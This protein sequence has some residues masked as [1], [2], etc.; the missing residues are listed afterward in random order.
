MSEETTK[1]PPPAKTLGVLAEFAG[2]DELVEAA[3]KTTDAGYRKVEAFSPFPIHGIDD[4]LRA[5]KTLLPWLVFGAGLSGCVIAIAM[6]YY[7]NATEAWWPFSGYQYNISAKP[8][9][10]LPANIPVTFE[11]IILLSAF[12]SFFGM[13]ALNGLPM[14][15]NPLFKSERFQTATSHGFFLWIDAQDGK[16]DKDGAAEFL[17][18]IGATGS[19][20]IEQETAGREIPGFLLA[21][22]AVATAI[23]LVPPLWVAAAAGK[24]SQPRLSIW[25]C[26]DY[27]PKYKAQS[28]TSRELFADGRSMRSKVEGTVPRG[29]LDTD[30]RYYEGIQSETPDGMAGGGNA[31]VQFVNLQDPGAEAAATPPEPDWTTEFPEQIPLTAE[32]M[33]RGQ[34]RFNIN[35]SACHGLDGK[36]LGL[37]TQR[38]LALQTPTWVRPTNVHTED[39]RKQPVGKLF[40]SITHGVRRMPGYGQQITVEDRWAIV[41]YVRALQRQQGAT[42]AD[43]PKAELKKLGKL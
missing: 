17:G 20:P 9:F 38:A 14:L 43:V 39:V 22:G 13:W 19:E 28:A 15:S 10:S 21:V 7:M 18:S 27:Q 5:P 25:W 16:F 41:M 42:E 12:G 1:T 3:A 11:L 24:S 37:V 34:E 36:G 2:P 26:M 31:S 32:T 33:N 40:H 30:L 8:F 35:C 29:T 4:A 23:A 6:Q